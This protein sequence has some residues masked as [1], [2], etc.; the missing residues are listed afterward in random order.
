MGRA[1]NLYNK[2]TKEQL[3]A[4]LSAHQADKDNWTP[5]GEDGRPIDTIWLYTAKSRKFQDDITWAITYHM[6]D[7]RKHLDS[8][9][10]V[11]VTPFDQY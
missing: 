5:R 9:F 8:S 7:E 2:K 4:M 1:Y 6:G 10:K 11:L 3:L